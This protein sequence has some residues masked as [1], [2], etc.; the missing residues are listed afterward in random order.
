MD[1]PQLIWSE[2]QLQLSNQYQIFPIIWLKYV[3]VNID[4]VNGLAYFEGIKIL[5]DTNPYLELLGIDFSFDIQAIINLKKQY[6]IFEVGYVWVVV[7][8]NPKEGISTLNL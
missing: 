4:R 7:S 1:K 6:M 8:L 5:D 3:E 2:T